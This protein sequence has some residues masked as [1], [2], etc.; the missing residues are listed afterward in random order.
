MQHPASVSGSRGAVLAGQQWGSLL[1]S[2][3]SGRTRPANICHEL[4]SPAA[5]AHPVNLEAFSSSQRLGEDLEYYER[6]VKE[7]G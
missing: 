3:P 1:P 4:P 7:A 5:M 6:P 2:E